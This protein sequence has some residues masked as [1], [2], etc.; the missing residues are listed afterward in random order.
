MLDLKDGAR[1]GNSVVAQTLIGNLHASFITNGTIDATRFETTIGNAFTMYSGNGSLLYGIV[2]GNASS[3]T[4]GTL[5]PN[6]FPSIIGNAETTVYYG[7]G[8]SLSNI[9]ASHISGQLNTEMLLGVG[10]TFEGNGTATPSSPCFTFEDNA[11][12]GLYRVGPGG[13]VGF[14]SNGI[15][16]AQISSSD[17]LVVNGRNVSS[18][19]YFIGNGKVLDG[20]VF[21]PVK[22]SDLI[23]GTL[24]SNLLPLSI[25]NADTLY[26][27]NAYGLS[28]T[29]AGNVVGTVNVDVLDFGSNTVPTSALSGDFD[30]D[31]VFTGNIN[32]NVF[33]GT[34]DLALN[35]EPS[36]VPGNAIYE[37][38]PSSV[39]PLTLGGPTTTFIGNGFGLTINTTNIFGSSLSV[40]NITAS[41]IVA[42]NL[43]TTWDGTSSLAFSATTKRILTQYTSSWSFDTEGDIVAPIGKT[44][45][46]FDSTGADQTF[47]VPAG[48]FHIYVKVWGAGG[49]AGRAGSWTYGSN[50][51]GGGHTRGLVP[52]TPGESLTVKVGAGGKLAVNATSY[53]GGAGGDTAATIYGGQGGGG[54]FLFRSSTPLLIAGGGGGGGSSRAWF[55]NCGGAGGGTLGQKGE[56]PYDAKAAYGG[57]GGSQTAGGTATGGNSGTLYV[58]GTSQTYAAG[59][60][61]GYYGGGGGGYSESN[62]MGGGG[63]GSGYV[64]S[65]LYMGGTFVGGFRVPALYWDADLSQAVSTNT[66]YAYGGQNTQNN[67]A[68]NAFSGG[69]GYVVLYY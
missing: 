50:G 59:G 31:V 63:G 34:I 45:I 8:Y 15:A 60:G 14:A 12:T 5:S 11:T 61:G 53:G 47:I 35:F 6:I 68:S 48:V 23:T 22:T 67:Q 43:V 18:T 10:G 57:T 19:N 29:R 28:S 62:T 25:G 1:F 65:G 33:V 41:N 9:N 7:N 32:A 4:S 40:A 17:G 55:G 38:I 56:S 16:L 49:G 24:Q 54:S 64:S 30:G 13:V 21:P 58:G 39:L 66:S 36:T 42:T 27:G 69:N 2:S 37:T 52:V 44:R 51:G 46:V 26:I 3:L 20:I